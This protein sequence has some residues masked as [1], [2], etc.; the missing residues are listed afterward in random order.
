MNKLATRETIANRLPLSLKLQIS[1]AQ[2]HIHQEKLKSQYDNW[3][4]LLNLGAEMADALYKKGA[5]Y[6]LINRWLA[7]LKTQSNA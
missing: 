3:Q 5:R 6:D 7:F 2:F 1:K 4:E